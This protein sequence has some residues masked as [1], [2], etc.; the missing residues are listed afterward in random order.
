MSEAFRQA[1]RQGHKEEARR[2]LGSIDDPELVVLSEGIGGARALVRFLVQRRHVLDPEPIATT[3]AWVAAHLSEAEPIHL[4]DVGP[5]LAAAEAGGHDEIARRLQA[6]QQFLQPP[7]PTRWSRPV[8]TEEDAAFLRACATGLVDDALARLDAQPEL[9][10]VRDAHG[11]DGIALASSHGD[12]AIEL[13][14]ALAEAGARPSA[15]TLGLLARGGATRSMD[16]LLERAWPVR[17]HIDDDALGI[18]AA[19]PADAEPLARLV[20]AGAD[21]NGCDRWG[22]TIWG[23]STARRREELERLGARPEASGEIIYDPGTGM[24]ARLAAIVDGASFESDELDLNEAAAA[25]DVARVDALL[26]EYGQGPR[27]A[28]SGPAERPM[29]LAAYMGRV[30]VIHR[31]IARGYS[32]GEINAPIAHGHHVGPRAT[33]GQSAVTVAALSL[34]HI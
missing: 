27:L 30:D 5:A 18:A 32:P 6:H 10:K 33:W 7:D 2:A 29:H 16:R 15:R 24:S 12:A 3:A 17:Q 21:P 25:G 20:E 26:E 11:C 13:T 31:L 34:I 9:A 1:C 28:R 22:V 8:P 4:L 19:G 23:A 14:T